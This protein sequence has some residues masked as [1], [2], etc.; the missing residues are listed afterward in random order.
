MNAG[1]V[2]GGSALRKEFSWPTRILLLAATVLVALSRNY[3]GVHTP[4]DTLVGIAV[5]LTVMW[6]IGLMMRWVDRHPNL[7]WIV[8]CA[9]F[10]LAAGLALYAALKP[11]PRD[12]DAEGKLIVDGAKMATDTFKGI[13]YAMGFLTGWILERRFVGFTVEVPAARRLARCAAGLFGFYAVTLILVP[14][15]R[16]LP[17]PVGAVIACFVQTFW[18]TF[19]FP[20]CFNL[21]GKQKQ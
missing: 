19:L 13:G 8:V 12:F 15:I 5:S 7:D 4:Q 17:D 18:I 20:W 3:L 16:E 14:W 9:G 2:F 1:T 11:Y 21:L 6:L 10:T